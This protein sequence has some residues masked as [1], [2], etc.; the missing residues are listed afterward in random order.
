VRNALGLEHLRFTGDPGKPVRSVAVLGGAGGS[1]AG[2]APADIDVFVTGDVKYHDALSALE[3]G[4]A[5]VDAGHAGTERGIV[6]VI[7]SYLRAAFPGLPV[8]VNH[9]PEVFNTV[10]A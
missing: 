3:R 4:L 1:E 10:T 9:E 8:A 7:A 6:D 5:V 2:K